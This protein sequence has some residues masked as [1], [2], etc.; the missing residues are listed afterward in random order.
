[1]GGYRGG[2]WKTPPNFVGLFVPSRLAFLMVALIGLHLL[3]VKLG[4]CFEAET[5][6][7]TL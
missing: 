5:I 6:P 4:K 1:M 7:F 3:H 2:W